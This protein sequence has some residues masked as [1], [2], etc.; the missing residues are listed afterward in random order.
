MVRIRSFT[1]Y[2]ISRRER[3]A[4]CSPDL[5][6]ELMRFAKDMRSNPL[7]I[8]EVR[9]PRGPYGT[10]PATSFGISMMKDHI[11]GRMITSTQRDGIRFYVNICGKVSPRKRIRRYGSLNIALDED[12]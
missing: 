6:D 3:D 9:S 7:A 10:Y 4:G 5:D 8:I 12:G 2:L 1:S 11:K